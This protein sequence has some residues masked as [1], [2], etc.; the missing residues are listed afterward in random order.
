MSQSY[1]SSWEQCATCDYWGG[2]RTTDTFGQNVSVNSAM[3]RGVC[4]CPTGNGWKGSQKPAN[5]SCQH[6]QKWGALR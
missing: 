2:Q 6:H 1:P 3:D 4:M 5:A